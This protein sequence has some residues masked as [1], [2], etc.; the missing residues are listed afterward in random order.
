MNIKLY[1]IA[2]PCAF[3]MGMQNILSMTK[4]KYVININNNIIIII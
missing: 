2:T 4:N 3:T 1:N